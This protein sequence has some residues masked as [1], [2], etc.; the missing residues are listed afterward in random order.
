MDKFRALV[1]A[2]GWNDAEVRDLLMFGPMMG[3]PP[4]LGSVRKWLRNISDPRASKIPDIET[5]L[6]TH[7]PKGHPK[8]K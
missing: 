4:S 7:S 2:K 5:F 3:D 6:K 8:L 1:K